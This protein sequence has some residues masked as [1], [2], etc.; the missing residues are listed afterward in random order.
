MRDFIRQAEL[1]WPTMAKLTKF[2]LVGATGIPVDLLTVYAFVAGL[3]VW[4]GWA[5]FGGFATAVTWNFFLNDRLTFSVKNGEQRRHGFFTRYLLF[6]G[7][8]SF[9]MVLNWGVSTALYEGT[10]FFHDHF[11]LAALLGVVAGT[12]TNFAGSMLL[13]FRETPDESLA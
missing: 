7:T 11:L 2:C 5:R 3:G 13:V 1:R 4:F 12:A 10:V 9:G 8:C 6:V